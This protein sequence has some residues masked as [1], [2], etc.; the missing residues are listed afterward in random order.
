MARASILGLDC[1]L[2]VNMTARPDSNNRGAPAV[3]TEWACIEDATMN[4]TLDSVQSTCRGAGGFKQN[5][6]TLAN[7]EITGTAIKTPSDPVLIAM[8]SAALARTIVEVIALDG[9]RAAVAADNVSGWHADMQ[10]S[11]FSEAQPIG[12]VVKI[13]F[14]L[15]VARTP[16]PPVIANAPL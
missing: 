7:L 13:S 3:F 10:F 15:V 6:P 1:R 8:Q 12:D 9:D 16:F 11:A 2:Y 4:L 14:T 5:S